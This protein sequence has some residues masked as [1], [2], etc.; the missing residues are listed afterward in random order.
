MD[1]LFIKFLRGETRMKKT[2]SIISLLL[3][4]M[5]ISACT[6]GSSTEQGNDNNSDSDN[7]KEE[8]EGSG[9]HVIGVS[10]TTPETGA[11][12]I[13]MEKFK[14]L[15]EEET[16]GDA[17]VELYPNGQLYASERE[18]VEAAQAGNVEMTVA[19]SA[20]VAGF[21]ERFMALDLPFIFPDH[22]TAYEALDG[23]FGQELLDGLPEIGLR[24]LGYGETGMRQFSNSKNPIETPSDLEGLKIRSMEN[25]VQIDTFEAYGANA[26]PFAFGELYSALQ[27]NTYDGMDNPINLIDQM[28]F[29][30]V[31][32][33]LTIS[34]HAYTA[35]VAF[36]ND[37][38]FNDLPE[39]IQDAVQDT[40]LESMDYQREEAR[41]QDEEGM[42]VIEENMEVKELSSEQKKE[43]IDKA[44]PIFE[45]YEDVIGSDLMDL[46]R[47]YADED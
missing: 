5:V 8:T 24:G 1:I 15:L 2:F 3:M 45:K 21:D 4:M 36:M 30:E 42:E 6:L 10:Y 23:E 11:T 20:P 18:A 43:F 13:G 44:E 38:F 31:Q 12:H 16:D 25:E 35:T 41:K 46:A 17:V 37:D 47:S 14:E 7:A 34:N 40:L 29:Y 32:D 9:E 28:K 26:S 39:D 19:A 33:Y 22:E 27:Q